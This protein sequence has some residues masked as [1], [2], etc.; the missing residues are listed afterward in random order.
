[1]KRLLCA[2]IAWANETG[3]NAD[4]PPPDYTLGRHMAIKSNQARPYEQQ[5]RDAQIRKTFIS[6]LRPGSEEQTLLQQW[7]N[8]GIKHG[9]R[10]HTVEAAK[11]LSKVFVILHAGLEVYDPAAAQHVKPTQDVARALAHGGRV[12]IR[13]PALRK[14]EH[15]YDLT[16][17]LG[18]TKVKKGRVHHEARGPVSSRSFGTHHMSIGKNQ[19]GQPGRFVE[20]GGG[21]ANRSNMKDMG[22][23]LYGMNVAA[24]GLGR[25]DFNGTVIMPDGGHGH[26][27]IGL[28]MP[29]KEKDGALQIGMETTAPMKSEMSP[30]GYIHDAH[31]TEATANP[32]SSFYGHKSAKIGGGGLGTNQ[33]LVDLNALEASSG[34]RW[35]AALDDIADQLDQTLQQ[36]ATMDAA[37]EMFVGPRLL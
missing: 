7:K 2:S 36:A 13:I 37:Y 12:N 14:G 16:D 33:R 19:P 24:G 22:V 32:E 20:K 34:K 5:E 1:A 10:E 30:V 25:Q 18:I 31:S 27:F 23:K 28:T 11:I 26:L 8:Q 3:R 6:V 35:E 29:T 4:N 9:T 17:W 15:E 21:A